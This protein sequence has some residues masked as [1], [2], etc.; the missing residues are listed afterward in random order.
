MFTDS[1][2]YQIGGKSM[3]IETRPSRRP[4]TEEG[5]G[6]PRAILALT[7]VLGL[8]AIAVWHSA[9]PAAPPVAAGLVPA[10]T[11]DGPG[12]GTGPVR[13]IPPGRLQV[14]VPILE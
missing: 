7:C 11:R 2:A 13:V 6:L 8:V 12:T 10:P 5:R 14:R 3:A 1:P 9:R 4:V